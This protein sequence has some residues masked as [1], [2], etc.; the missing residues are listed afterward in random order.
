MIDFEKHR[1]DKIEYIYNQ[2]DTNLNFQKHTHR[3]FEV[4]FVF[5]GKIECEIDGQIFNINAG[6]GV[7]ILPGQI[8]SYKT[9]AASKSYLCVFSNDWVREFYNSVKGNHFENP[10]FCGFDKAQCDILQN[11]NADK[12]IIKSILYGIC[13]EVFTNS[14]LVKSNA[15][16]F[17]LVNSLAFYVQDNYKNNISLKQIAKDFGYNYCYLSSFFNENFGMNFSAYVNSYRIQLSCE[18]LIK[19]DLDIT[20]ISTLCGFETIRNF[21][22]LFKK[23]CNMTPNEYRKTAV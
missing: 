14:T 10:V 4:M 20:E 5:E 1:S 3:S 19:T 18:Y 15:A 8:H 2:N 17:A 7:L 13:S 23:E 9:E 21:N 16:N 6:E 11:K 12:F 22:R